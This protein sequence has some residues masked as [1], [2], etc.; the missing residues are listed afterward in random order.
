MQAGNTE[1]GLDVV[2]ISAADDTAA[3]LLQ[4]MLAER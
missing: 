2:D 1:P 4:R 3:V